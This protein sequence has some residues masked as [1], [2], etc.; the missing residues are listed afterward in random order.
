MRWLR[1]FAA[2]QGLKG[3]GGCVLLGLFAGAALGLRQLSL[4]DAHTAAEALGVAMLT[5]AFLSGVAGQPQSLT[6]APLLQSSFAVELVGGGQHCL[7]G[8]LPVGGEPAVNRLKVAKG[9]VQRADQRF[10]GIGPQPG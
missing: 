10:G 3:S 1:S 2:L 6:L 4:L 8:G 5:A 7:G 9:V